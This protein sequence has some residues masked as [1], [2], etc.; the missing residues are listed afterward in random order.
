MM[1]KSNIPFE[2]SD[3]ALRKYFTQTA[4]S[5]G[6]MTAERVIAAV[7][8]GGDSAALLWMCAHFFHGKVTALHVNH[9][10]RGIEADGDEAFTEEF[11]HS[12]GCEF[13]SMKVDVPASRRKGETLEEC[14]R[15]I[16]HQ[17]IMQAAKSLNIDTVLLGHNKDDLAETVLFNLLRGTGIRGA[18]GITES[19]CIGGVRVYRPLLG[20]RRKFLRD[21][22]TA[23]GIS[24]REDS[25]N[26]NDTFTRNYIR[27]K[28]LP[29]IEQNINASA[30]EHLADFGEDMMRVREQE[31]ELSA[32]LF[33]SCALTNDVIDWRKLKA[34]SDYETSLVIREAGRRL[35]LRTLSRRRCTGLSTLIHKG[36]SFV[37]QWCGRV[38]VT[39]RK[40]RITIHEH[41]AD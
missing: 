29:V 4:R 19:S 13:M 31:D 25:S 17:C 6:W 10:I 14:A 7:S 39:G 12:A 5:Q 41:S 34:L 38:V 23:R 35:G 22:L 28:L 1:Q 36:N 2:V 27:L 8:G 20:L 11:A 40:G 16:R 30:V 37:F 24:W 18:V 15:R 9:G 3:Y 26:N 33:T 32:K 21:I